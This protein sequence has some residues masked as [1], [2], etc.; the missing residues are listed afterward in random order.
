MNGIS[1][2]LVAQALADSARSI[3]AGRPHGIAVDG[4][5]RIVLVASNLARLGLAAVFAKA[6]HCQVVEDEPRDVLVLDCSTSGESVADLF[7]RNPGIGM[8]VIAPSAEPSVLVDELRAGARGV[9][10]SE[11]DGG[12][13]IDAVEFVANGGTYVS[14]DAASA[15]VEW[16]R[17]GRPPFDPLERLSD[18]ERRIVEFIA[19]GMTNRGIAERLGLSEHTVKTYVS[20][21]LRKLGFKNRAQAA[22]VIARHRP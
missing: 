8:V 17:A 19:D 16:F 20:S 10:V 13:L 7:G 2:P 22:A 6:R 11:L 15:I 1:D 9:L 5:V 12:R 18:Q 21:A 14:A 3:A 4:P